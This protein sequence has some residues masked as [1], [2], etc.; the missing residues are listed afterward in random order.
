MHPSSYFQHPISVILLNTS[1]QKTKIYWHFFFFFFFFFGLS[2]NE[3]NT[4]LTFFW[5]IFQNN[6]LRRWIIGTSICNSIAFGVT[7]RIVAK[8]IS[9]NPGFLFFNIFKKQIKPQITPL[10][11]YESW[12]Q[13]GGVSSNEW[14]ILVLHL[15]QQKKRNGWQVGPGAS[16][17]CFLWRRRGSLSRNYMFR[18]PLQLAGFSGKFI[19]TWRS[20]TYL[21]SFKY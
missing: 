10:E 18:V 2:C 11:V 13:L 17:G 14:P 1:S 5:L 9:E 6:S 16:Q 20:I 7:G 4:L 3:L 21:H 8:A 15:W 12:Q 19:V